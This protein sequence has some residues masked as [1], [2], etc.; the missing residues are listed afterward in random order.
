M[1]TIT[2]LSTHQLTLLDAIWRCETSA[3]ITRYVSGLGT[4]D[5]IMATSLVQLLIIESTDEAQEESK[6]LGLAKK[7]LAKYRL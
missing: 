6:D 7:V 4:D 2:H 5:R 1:I 3:D